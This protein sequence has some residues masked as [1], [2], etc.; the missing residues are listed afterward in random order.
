MKKYAIYPIIC[1]YLCW[2][3]P[4]CSDSKEE[5]SDN[6]TPTPESQ[7]A[8][9]QGLSFTDAALTQC[10]TFEAGNTWKATLEG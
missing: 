7:T 10:I 3:L 9:S 2:L 1:L 5:F 4:A 8:F 6:H